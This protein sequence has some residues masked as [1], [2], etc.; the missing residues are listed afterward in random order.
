MDCTSPFQLNTDFS[1]HNVVVQFFELWD[2]T[3]K[4]K[5]FEKKNLIYEKIKSFIDFQ[6]GNFHFNYFQD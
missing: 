6:N 3:L 5:Q 4:V 2:I 1:F